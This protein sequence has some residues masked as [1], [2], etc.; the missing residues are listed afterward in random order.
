MGATG[1]GFVYNK[2]DAV[3]FDPAPVIE[4]ISE[5]EKANAVQDQKIET[6]NKNVSEM[7]SDIKEIK[8]LLYQQAGY[9]TPAKELV[10]NAPLIDG[11]APDGGP[12]N[13]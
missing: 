5:T 10:K 8:Q 11:I 4:R 1:V 9:N 3:K 6:T 13:R 7:K 2:T 12:K